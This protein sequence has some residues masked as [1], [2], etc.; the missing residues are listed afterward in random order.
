MSNSESRR[1]KLQSILE[2]LP[3]VVEAWFQPPADHKMI[4]PAI[5]YSLDGDNAFRAD[6]RRYVGVPR[7]S[8]ILIDPNP[9]SAIKDILL[10]T[11][12]MISLDRTYTKD[13]LNHWV[14]TLYF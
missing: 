2:N 14:F 3:G 7:Y 8:L 6:D 1:I 13:N 10:D 5:R 12:E 4:Y 11:F 9:T